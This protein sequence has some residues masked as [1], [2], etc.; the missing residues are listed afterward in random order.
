[1]WPVEYRALAFRGGSKKRENEENE[2]IGIQ[3]LP[4]ELVGRI[5][6]DLPEET[7]VLATFGINAYLRDGLFLVN[8]CSVVGIS[9]T[10]IKMGNR[11]LRNLDLHQLDNTRLTPPELDAG[12]MYTTRSEIRGHFDLERLKRDMLAT[13]KSTLE[14]D[15]K[16]EMTV[17]ENDSTFP[18]S[19]SLTVHINV[20]RKR[21]CGGVCQE[22]LRVQG[23]KVP[24]ISKTSFKLP[25][26]LIPQVTHG[27]G[28]NG[29]I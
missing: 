10:Q 3:S 17:I 11:I 14:T 16:L 20:T 13:A 22:W 24:K 7:T 23:R 6:D 21:P 15:E 26:S 18:N 27:N 25:E 4:T 29:S 8:R 2:E 28:Y 9:S 12:G 5:F 1:M 19:R